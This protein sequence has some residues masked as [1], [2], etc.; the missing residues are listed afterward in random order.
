VKAFRRIVVLLVIASLALTLIPANA[1]DKSIVISFEQ[2]ADGLNPM[3]STMTF[4]NFTRQLFLAG[5]WNYD[6]DLNPNPVLVTE[7]PSLAN[8]G[9]SEDGTSITLTLRDDIVW[10]DGEPITAADFV[11]TYEMYMDPANSPISRDPYDKIESITAVDDTTVEIVFPEPYA[12]WLGLFLNG[13]LPKHVLGPVFEADGT[14]DGAEWNRAPYVGNGAFVFD[15]WETGS[16]FRFVRNENYYNEP[17]KLDTVIVSI[18][19]DSEAYVAGLTN[20]DADLGYFFPYDSIAEIEAGGY[21]TVDI[22]AGGYNEAWRLNVREGLGHPAL[23]DVR[24]RQALAMAFDRWKICEDLMLGYTYPASSF[25]EQTPYENPEV[26]PY[27]YDPEAAAALLDEAGWV[28][29]NGDGT[30]DKDGVELVLRYA[31]NTRQVRQDVQVVVQQDFA[32]L[33]IGIEIINHPSDIYWNS[34]ADGG[35][36]ALGEYDIAEYSSSPNAWPEPDTTDF[37]CAQIPSED[38]LAGSNWTGTCDPELDALFEEQM[39]TVDFDARV[40]VYHK[41]DQMMH[42]LAITVG[43]WY[44]ADTWFTSNRLVGVALNGNTPFWNVNEWDVTE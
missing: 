7:M 5:A 19:P 44:D 40:A 33:G 4:A 1:Q 22:I 15:T 18:V 31:T 17:A 26:E 30:R 24:V 39:S 37:T 28:D 43:V 14:L 29:S 41:I 34:Y 10:S 6:G 23:Q 25:W 42:D 36:L 38:N 9:I 3:Y 16:F 11:F 27:P 2:E 20:G 8:G 35:P 13:I 21:G 32:E 12:P